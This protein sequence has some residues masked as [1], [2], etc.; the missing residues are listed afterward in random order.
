[1]NTPSDG[2]GINPSWGVGS[3]TG[4]PA[5]PPSYEPTPV[6][7]DSVP[8]SETPPVSSKPTSPLPVTPPPPPR[9][10]RQDTISSASNATL[11]PSKHP[12]PSWIL[13]L[14]LVILIGGGLVAAGW[15]GIGFG[16]PQDPVKA[17]GLMAMKLEAESSYH[18]VGDA[19]VTIGPPTLIDQV[20]LLPSS[21]G[22][23][24]QLLTPAAA[25][26]SV[27]ADDTILTED[28]SIAI[29]IGFESHQNHLDEFDTTL[30][31][32]GTGLADYLVDGATSITI[33]FR[34]VND[35]FYLRVPI[36][37]LL[38]GSDRNPWF[39]F[40]ADDLAS[41]TGTD[42]P[43]S[44]TFDPQSIIK[45]GQRL[46]FQQINGA[47]TGHYQAE[48]DLNPLLS[49]ADALSGEFATGV[50]SI[51]PIQM[52][53]WMGLF[54]HLPRRIEV[55]GQQGDEY[56]S[57]DLSL[58]LTFDEYGN[59]FT[60]EPPAP[61]EIDRGGFLELLGSDAG[62]TLSTGMEIETRDAYRK[63]DLQTLESA[64]ELYKFDHG[65]YPVTG[66][67]SARTN[68]SGNVLE[69]LVGDY[70][71][72]LPVDPLNEKYFYGYLSP[73]GKGYE[74]WSILESPDDPDAVLKDG[75]TVYNIESGQ[76][77]PDA[78]PSESTTLPTAQVSWLEITEDDA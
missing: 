14:V 33:D 51:P 46:G 12:R 60:I 26:T 78:A 73:D 28:A 7:A 22:A 44:S 21:R 5:G 3:G 45:S 41:L 8:R 11:P 57:T 71:I 50:T 55:Y 27:V 58:A 36:L 6:L 38:V 19:T 67:T 53:W 40:Q 59:E 17:L 15:F 74:L 9:L 13:P 66:G 68:V 70:L 1:M 61:E 24:V 72:K 31:V 34:R 56:V 54:D 76:S 35:Q 39:E 47:W 10:S 20:S 23:L 63:S 75:Y 30:T 42:L 43:E 2:P 64:L 32:S 62:T 29:Q 16:L 65:S 4:N 25:Q 77:G 37:S 18:L 48:L 69:A 49:G 52:E